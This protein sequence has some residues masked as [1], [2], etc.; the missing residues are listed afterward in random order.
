[1]T[2]DST[3]KACSLQSYAVN[4]EVPSTFAATSCHC[5]QSL[6]PEIRAGDPERA[7]TNMSEQRRIDTADPG[8]S[9][10]NETD[11]DMSGDDMLCES[12]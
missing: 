5:Y 10:M 12:E 4:C 6:T 2:M 11:I 8:M 9:G 1:M 3:N 7:E